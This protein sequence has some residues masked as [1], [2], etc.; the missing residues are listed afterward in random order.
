MKKQN[1]ST[2][3]F[4]I[5]ALCLCLSWKRSDEALLCEKNKKECKL[6]GSD[7]EN[8]YEQCLIDAARTDEDS[9]VSHLSNKAT[10]I[11][12]K[13]TP[14]EKQQAMDFADNDRMPPEDAVSKVLHPDT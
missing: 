5:S 11:Y 10:V 7:C 9:F 4:A 14:E 8:L 3:L 2:I 1:R 13:F 12:N 6:K